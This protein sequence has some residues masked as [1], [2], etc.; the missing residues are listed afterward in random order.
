VRRI[1]DT[2]TEH[3]ARDYSH[4]ILRICYLHKKTIHVYHFLRNSSVYC[5]SRHPTFLWCVG[6]EFATELLQLT[7]NM[8][9][10]PTLYLSISD[11]VNLSSQLNKFSTRLVTH[12]NIF[13]HTH[14]FV[15]LNSVVKVCSCWVHRSISNSFQHVFMSV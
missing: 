10:F 15:I 6:K 2:D 3:S 4:T 11:L 9:G 8:R 12:F 5:T 14:I 1:C 7:K 13:I